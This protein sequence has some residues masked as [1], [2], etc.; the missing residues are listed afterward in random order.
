MLAERM[1]ERSFWKYIVN[2]SRYKI[3]DV[4]RRKAVYEDTVC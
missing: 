3:L 4:W 1:Q 2:G